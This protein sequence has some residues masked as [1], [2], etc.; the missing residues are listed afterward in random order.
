MKLRIITRKDEIHLKKIY[1]D[2][3]NSIDEKIYTQRQKLA[4]SSQAWDN[5]E[6]KNSIIKGKGLIIYDQHKII[7]FAVRYPINKLA[8]FYIRGDSKRKG[9]GTIL[10]KNIEK[11]A[12]KDGLTKIETEASLIS[13]RLLQ[14]NSWKIISKE[15]I[16]IK[17]TLFERYKMIKNFQ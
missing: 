7:G 3:I 6:F 8:L 13:Y 15:R 14:K 4:W 10:L 5:A 11:D 1:F 17:D 2:S 9:Y 12:I 16:I